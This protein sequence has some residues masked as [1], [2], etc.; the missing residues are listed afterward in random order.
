M[1]RS[2]ENDANVRKIIQR[3]HEKPYRYKRHAFSQEKH[4]KNNQATTKEKNDVKHRQRI[5]QKAQKKK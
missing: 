2:Q 4:Q 1:A 5:N 3:I